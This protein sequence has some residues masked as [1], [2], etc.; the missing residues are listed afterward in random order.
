MSEQGV[1]AA[2]LFI[3]ACFAF[4]LVTI[5]A[6]WVVE[7]R[8]GDDATITYGM[9][10]LSRHLPLLTH[11]LVFLLGLLV[12]GLFVHFFGAPSLYWP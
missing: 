4:V 7:R 5:L 11:I 1:T 9:R 12:G 8:Q 6:D 10:W 2:G 3:V